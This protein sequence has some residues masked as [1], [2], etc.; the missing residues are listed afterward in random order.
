MREHVCFEAVDCK[1]LQ[2]VRASNSWV[3]LATCNDLKHVAS[4]MH[5]KFAR[6]VDSEK[7]ERRKELN[8]RFL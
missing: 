3:C 5:C 4:C 2:Y 6:L 1:L 8:G 7:R